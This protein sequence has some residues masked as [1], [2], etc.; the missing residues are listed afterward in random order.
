MSRSLFSQSWYRVAE[1]CLQVRPH[2]RLDRHLL[3][4]RRWYVAQD[5][6]TGRHYRLSPAAHLMVCLMDGR[7]TLQEIWEIAA[8]RFGTEQPTQDETI[9]LVAQLYRADLLICSVAPDAVEL[10]RRGARQEQQ[11][12]LRRIR[13][14]LVLRVPLVDPDV[15]LTRTAPLVQPLFGC[16]G[17]LLWLA[18]MCIAVLLALLHRVDLAADLS[19]RIFSATTLVLL[20]LA[21]PAVKALHEL[22]HAYATK[23]WGGEVHEMGIMMLALFPVPYVDASAASAFPQKWRRVVVG[24]AG[25]MVELALAAFALIVWVTAQAGYVRALAF[26][27]MLIGG[28]STVLFNG[29]PLLRFDGYFVLS[30]L[31]EIPNLGTRASAYMLWLL[32]NY[33]FGASDEKGRSETAQ[34]S[35]WLL[36][37]AIAA[38]FYRLVV[39][40]GLALFFVGK[41]FIIGVLLALWCI[42]MMI[43]WPL[44]KGL[45]YL[46]RDPALN[47][48]RRRAVSVSAALVLAPCAVLALIPVPYATVV[49]GVVQVPEK[50]VLRAATDGFVRSIAV[51]PGSFVGPGQTLIQLDDPQ[52]HVLVQLLNAER[53]EYQ[54]RFEAVQYTDLVQANLL[55]EQVRRIEANLALAQRRFAD[56]SVRS[57]NSGQF[58]LSGAP[59]LPGRFVRR[60][61]FLGYVVGEGDVTVRVVVSQAD[62]N[63]VRQRVQR[64]AVRYSTDLGHSVPARLER[65]TPA[66]QREMPS[67]ALGLSAGGDI[68]PDP[69]DATGRS[70]FERAFLI[71]VAPME[72]PSLS[73]IG[74]RVFVRFEH[75]PEPLAHRLLRRVRQIFLR[76]LNV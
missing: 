59:D 9:Q 48:V 58:I 74:G 68:L 41:F 44:A 3:R 53:S 17:L 39:T 26:T 20:A 64:I 38:F 72:E 29:N 21:Y 69:A 50:A 56:L 37:Y 2:V 31:L 43:V 54:L 28:V 46:W 71:D 66:A 24:A 76:H 35:L 62:V 67:A 45:A 36:V 1:V 7:R 19:D 18:L 4:G 27:V 65:E 73:I 15:F 34:E 11:Q 42:V 6:Q 49:Q 23:V 25:I 57:A 47:G 70:A 52:I 55:R 14:P 32:R 63:L 30:D 51:A 8:R 40:F 13:N 10:F 33:A 75:P 22:G 16:V 12:M 61:D 5:R 60:G